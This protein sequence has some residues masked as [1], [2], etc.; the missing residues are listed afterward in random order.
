MGHYSE[1]SSHGRGLPDVLT[2]T[3]RLPF[4]A[5]PLTLPGSLHPLRSPKGWAVGFHWSPGRRAHG[6][7][8]CP[9]P[10]RGRTGSQE[11]CWKS[12]RCNP[13]ISGYRQQPESG[14]LIPRGELF[15]QSAEILRRLRG[16]GRGKSH[17]CHGCIC[18][19]LGV[20]AGHGKF[21]GG[22]LETWDTLKFHLFSKTHGVALGRVYCSC[23]IWS[24][25]L[26]QPD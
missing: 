12:G 8:P 2:L 19:G 25:V 24:S 21:Y 15:R 6:R 13:G 4:S 1:T 11:L 26:L 14:F 3:V 7:A 5:L 9:E 16:G 22:F 18:G 17:S 20:T 10:C 23:K